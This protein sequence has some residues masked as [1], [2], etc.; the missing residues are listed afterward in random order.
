M[1]G[2]A[3][4]SSQKPPSRLGR[5]LDTYFRVAAESDHGK[6]S[7]TLWHGREAPTGP[8]ELSAYRNLVLEQYKVYAEMAD[9]VSARRGLA[10]TFFLTLNTAIVA[11]AGVFW[12]HPTTANRWLLVVPW[13]VMV[14]Q[15]LAWFWI[16]RSY[17]Q[18]NAAKYAVIGAME[19]RLPASPYWSAEWTAL[20]EGKDPARYWPFSHV[21][22][23]IPTFFAAAYT[24]GLL[25]LVLS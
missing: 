14:G 23:W 15:C 18:L 13:L 17:R 8:S 5:L 22:R 21:E 11:L 4:T 16:L 9:R 20:G 7:T 1:C 24:A 19:E 2:M 12:Q 3:A 25:A 10:N 6:I